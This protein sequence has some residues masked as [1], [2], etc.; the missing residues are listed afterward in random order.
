MESRCQEERHTTVHAEN[1]DL[2]SKASFEAVYTS[3]R[4]FRMTRRFFSLMRIQTA[5]D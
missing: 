4:G 5:A 2:F 1:A 3:M